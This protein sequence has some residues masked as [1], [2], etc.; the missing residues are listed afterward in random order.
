VRISSQLQIK[1]ALDRLSGRQ[2]GLEQARDRVAS[3]RRLNKPSDDVTGTSRAM[4]LKSG[5]RIREQE[6]RNASDGLLWI[7]MADSKLQAVSDRLHR[8]RELAIAGG[9]TTAALEGRAAAEE[10]AG[11]RAELVEI[12]NSKSRGR[13]LFAGHAAG[14]AVAKIG[15][16]WT[17][18][19]DSGVVSRRVAEGEQVAINVTADDVF[20]FASGA[21][22]FSIFDSLEAALLAG[23]TAGANAGL[24]GIDGALEHV[25]TGLARLGA[26]SNHLESAETRRNADV[27]TITSR[28]SQIED[29]DLAEAIMELQLQEVGYQAALQAYQRQFQP[30]L[31]DFLR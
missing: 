12:A 15:G 21:D 18:T 3:G 23:D 27:V 9:S 29:V 24:A 7:N 2:V 20:G 14:D 25:L 8:V 30:S 6:V 22:V 10:L 19:G 13:G 26:A 16:V 31:V 11:I 5:L 28:L 17:Y 4:A 1:A